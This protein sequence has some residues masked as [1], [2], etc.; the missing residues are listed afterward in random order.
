[1]CTGQT[2]Q[3]AG[4]TNPGGEGKTCQMTTANYSTGDKCS[5]GASTCSMMREGT[6]QGLSEEVMF[7]YRAEKLG[8]G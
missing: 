8:R 1:M 4:F 2:Q 5:Q 6:R 3:E 7:N